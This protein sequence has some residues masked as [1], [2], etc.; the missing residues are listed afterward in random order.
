VVREGG[1]E[2]LRHLEDHTGE[3]TVRRSLPV[4][5]ALL[6]LLS[7]I[8]G[9]ALFIRWFRDPGRVRAASPVLRGGRVAERMGCA[10]CHGPAGTGGIPNAG[11]R[12]GE[13]PGWVGGTYMMYNHAPEEIR[14]WILD[15][16]PAR[17]RENPED[18]ERRRV[19]LIRMPAYRGILNES[20]LDDLVAYVQSVSG[21]FRPPP[22]GPA[23]GGRDLAVAHG[24]FGCHGP[25][26]RGLVSNPGSLRGFIPPWD[27]PDYEELVATP[28]E[29]R[30]WVMS[31]EIKR[32]RENPAAAHFLDSQVVKMPAFRGLMTDDEV[33]RLR[34][35]VEWVRA[36]PYRKR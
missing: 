13:V 30:E 22:D 10:G 17:L 21:A 11:A 19:Q 32:F 20:D 16:V 14:E 34:A 29:F 23:A 31:G 1:D 28:E 35:Y 3:V 26:G 36:R 18:V 7:L 4:L 2:A 27:S 5:V 33:D 24:C 6:G 8:E 15:G 25:E 12:A 9:A